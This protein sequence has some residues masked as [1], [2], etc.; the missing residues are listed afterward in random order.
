MLHIKSFWK[1]Y[2]MPAPILEYRFAKEAI[3]RNWRTD[4]CWPEVKLA[5]ETEGAIYKIGKDG[6]QGGRHNRPVGF[7]KDME[8]YNMLTE[9]GWHLLRYEPKKVDYDQ[10]A[11][12]YHMLKEKDNEKKTKNTN[13]A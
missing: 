6:K 7:K 11:R 13:M 12:C 9:L 4:Y 2:N 5:V 1:K 10:I 8:K 3:N